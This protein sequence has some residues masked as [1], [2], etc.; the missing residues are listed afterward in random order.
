MGI[1][2]GV[3]NQVYITAE[4][5]HRFLRLYNNSVK[6]K[7]ESFMFLGQE[8]IVSYAKYIVE[9]YNE[10]FTSLKNK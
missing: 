10:Q 9:A 6:D 1:T 7:K 8:I 5:Y 2:E 4:N 3:K